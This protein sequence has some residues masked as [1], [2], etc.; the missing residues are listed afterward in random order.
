MIRNYRRLIRYDIIENGIDLTLQ[1]GKDVAEIV[2]QHLRERHQQRDEREQRGVSQRRRARRALDVVELARHL[3]HEEEELDG[4][5]ARPRP[6]VRLAPVEQDH[7]VG[8]PRPRH[9]P[10]AS[11]R[12][13]RHIR[14]RSTIRK[15]YAVRWWP[16]AVGRWPRDRRA[17]YGG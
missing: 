4:G 2:L 1:V 17:A 11:E 7:R 13:L 8:Q 5:H 3:A 14:H 15:P 16:L 12:R 10:R 9:R 6:P